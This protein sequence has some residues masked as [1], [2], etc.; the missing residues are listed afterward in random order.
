MCQRP[1]ASRVRVRGARG[2]PA[3]GRGGWL[4]TPPT[5]LVGVVIVGVVLVVLIVWACYAT[6]PLPLAD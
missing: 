5:A 4:D 1:D 2:V 6:F 3:G